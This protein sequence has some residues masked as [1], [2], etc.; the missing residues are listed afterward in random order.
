M[1]VVAIKGNITKEPVLMYTGEKCYT[2]FSIAVNSF[3]KGEKK[4]MFFDVLAF[5]KNAELICQYLHKGSEIPL[6]GELHQ[7]TYKNKENKTMT[8]VWICLKS[9]DFVSNKKETSKE[10]EDS[11]KPF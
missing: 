10:T 7:D 3:A 1:N 8:A 11:F 9:F 5:G 2:R 4:A 6:V